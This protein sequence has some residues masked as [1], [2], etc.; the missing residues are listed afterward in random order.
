MAKYVFILSPPFSGSTLLHQLVAGSQSVSEIP[1]EGLFLPPVKKLLP[2]DLY[3]EGQQ[4]PWEAV[5]R[6]WE[7]VWDL[8]KPIL[9]EK[10]PP[11]IVHA[12]DIE[13]HFQ[14][15]YFI[16]IVR[17][18]YAYCEGHHRRRGLGYHFAAQ[19]WAMQVRHQIRNLESLQNALLVSYEQLSDDPEAT[20]DRLIEFLPELDDIDVHA[21]FSV[22]AVDNA[23]KQKSA[24]RNLNPTKIEMLARRDVAE[25]NDVLDEHEDL[26]GYFGYQRIDPNRHEQV[27]QQPVAS[28]VRLVRLKYAF[29]RFVLR[30][31]RRAGLEHWLPRKL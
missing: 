31:L 21:E 20:R 23:W 29:K 9:M 16:C 27:A 7:Q 18:P 10:S 11:A 1:G 28:G 25:I 3:K 24:I 6:E 17:D 22:K 15:A 5:R 26:M 13:R 2:R 14:P 19:R 8:G 30:I 4:I 12:Q